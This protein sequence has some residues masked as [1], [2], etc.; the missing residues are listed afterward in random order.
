MRIL[1][2]GAKGQLGVDVVNLLDKKHEVIGMDRQQLDVT[3]PEECTYVIQRLQPD[4]VIHCAAFT[5]VDLAER[6]ADQAFLVNAKGSRN[7]AIASE[8]VGAKIVYISTDYVFDGSHTVPY[9]ANDKTNPINVYGKSKLAGEHFI[10]SHSSKYYIIRTSWL[11][12]KYGNN[13]VKT[14]LKLS[15][16]RDEITVV[17]DQLGS[18]T[19]TIDLVKFL[20]NLIET[21]HYGIYHASNTGSCTW[22]EFA[23]AIFKL[24]N[25][26]I[27][28]H[29]CSTEEYQIAAPRPMYSVL[30]HNSILSHGFQDLRPWEEALR[31]YL[32]DNGTIC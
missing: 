32:L 17:A 24:S 10:Q 23:Q 8:V 9:H 13:F 16:T 18:P 2:T 1:V 6:E 12:G 26:K 4:V 14:M 27:N 25:I 28:V 31:A 5:Q 20:A 19:Y 3:N 11:Y 29:P 21:D 30:D 22:Y 7:I 15:S